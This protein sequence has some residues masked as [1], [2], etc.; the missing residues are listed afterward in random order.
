[1][2][3]IVERKEEKFLLEARNEH[4]NTL[5]MDADE[6]IG[7]SGEGMRPMQLL[8]AAPGGC[9]SIDVLLIL[10]KQKQVITSY[11]VEVEGEKEKVEDHSEFKKIHLSF[12]LEGQVDSQKAIHAVQM[13]MEKYCSVSKTLAKTAEI[14]YSVFVNNQKA[15]PS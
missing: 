12:Y 4:G 1:M 10:S 2:K 9:S 3:I 11:R 14:K 8:L 7:G 6:K 15:Y 5:L 13:S